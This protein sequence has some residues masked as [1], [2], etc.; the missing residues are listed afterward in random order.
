VEAG[1]QQDAEQVDLEALASLLS[2]TLAG[3]GVPASAEANLVLVDEDEIA[4]LNAEHLGHE[5]PTDVLSFP[6]DGPSL[7]LA[8]ASP[9]AHAASHGAHAASL[10]AHA[11]SLG[12][13]AASLGAHAASLGAHAATSDAVPVGATHPDGVLVGDVVI[14]PTVARRNAEANGLALDDELRLLVVHGALHLLG[15]DHAD[16]AGAAAMRQRE[17]R[18]AGRSGARAP[19]GEAP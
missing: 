1:D 11:A 4:Q 14:C 12:A 19:Q 7:A 17:Q 2:R 10:G 16:E 15:H 13:H 18:Y 5:G 3:E 6:I 8:P 9:G